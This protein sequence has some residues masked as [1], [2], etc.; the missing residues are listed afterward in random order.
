MPEIESRARQAPAAAGAILCIVLFIQP[1]TFMWI[2]R[3]GESIVRRTLLGAGVPPYTCYSAVFRPMCS[4]AA[5]ET[6][7]VGILHSVGG[8]KLEKHKGDRI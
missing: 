7:R 4:L 5:T 1:L 8:I 2:F 3:T 6:A